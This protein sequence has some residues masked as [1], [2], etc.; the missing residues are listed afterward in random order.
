M[1]DADATRRFYGRWA[2][3]YDRVAT[4]P[5]VGA[6]RAAATDALALSPGETVVEMGCGT[7]ANLPY[8]RER[9]GPDGRV[10]GVDVTRGVLDRARR[11]VERRGWRNVHPVQADATR[12]PVDGPVDAVLG[13]FVCGMFPDPRGTVEGWLDLLAP[14]GR[15]ALLDAG[16]SDRVAAAPLNLAFRAFV[17]ASNPGRPRERLRRA[18]DG[19]GPWATLDER[20]AAAS[21][22]VTDRCVDR[23]S[24]TFALGFVR[25]VAG[26][27][28]D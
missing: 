26:R 18:V 24:A 21:A 11:R 7:G 3:L 4:A 10:V 12:V 28:P 14:G 27:I 2:G 23:Q 13:T 22:A 9:V 25:L 8:L 19:E 17:L 1:V 20:I 16:Q 6:W 5:G 15:I